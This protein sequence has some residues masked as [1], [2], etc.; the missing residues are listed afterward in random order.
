[1]EFARTV[2]AV[3]VVVG[4]TECV[5]QSGVIY[6]GFIHRYI[7]ILHPPHTQVLSEGKM[8]FAKYT[9]PGMGLEVLHIPLQRFAICISL[10]IFYHYK[11]RLP[12]SGG[13]VHDVVGRVNARPCV[14]RTRQAVIE[15]Y[16]DSLFHISLSL[17]GRAAGPWVLTCW[18]CRHDSRCLVCTSPPSLP[19]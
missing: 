19:C 16:C 9:R 7:G 5:T 14:E 10:S 18:P 4:A 1:M 11:C 2:A 12:K 6:F 8:P 3:G 17:R 15:V 13:A